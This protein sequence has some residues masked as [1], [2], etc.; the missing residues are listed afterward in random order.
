M[1]TEG[2]DTYWRLMMIKKLRKRFILIATVAVASVM[3]LLCVT[4][5][6]ANFVSV[7]SRLNRTVDMIVSNSGMM[8]QFD[9]R[10]PAP[11]ANVPGEGM[12]ADRF[13]MGGGQFNEETP[14]STR[15]FVLYYNADGTLLKSDLDK[16]AAVTQDDTS[17]YLELALKHGEGYG[18]ADGYKYKVEKQSDSSYMA[19]F[20]DD[21]REMNSLKTVLIFSVIATVV[22]IVLIYVLIVLF[23]GKAMRPVEQSVLKQ[24]QF[25][26]DA[27]HE[28]KTP[29][30]V[31]ATSMSVLE[32]EV[33][34]QKWIDKA[35]AQTEKLGE[36]VNSL[37]ALAKMDELEEP[38][39]VRE[40]DVSESLGETA[41]SFTDFAQSK[42]LSL[43]IKVQPQLRY[44]G[45]EYAVRQLA[46]ILIDNA[47]KYAVDGTV[48]DFSLEKGKKGIV[49][50]T[51]NE[52]E[53]IET[54]DL[55]RLFDRFYR[56]DKARSSEKGGFGI[57]LS[58]ARS[59]CEAHKGSIKASCDN[60]HTIV[61]TA[62]LK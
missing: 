45:D 5:N 51:S 3:L 42:G 56:A 46:S 40:F 30:T 26:T 15:F 4:V 52:C 58:I 11:D 31:I 9:R 7:N 47:I 21:Y 54:D 36:L 14:F 37:V 18:F 39:N 13:D 17:G 34:K 60:G 8:P 53:K 6:A 50:K 12:R 33:G 23:S 16:I 44:S 29:I 59:I 32:M 48:I 38:S 1:P 22:C 49:I 10:E 28:L 27:S 55:D 24:K 20:L 2:S 62:Q 19:V 41:D 25:I 57:G 35:K 61:F 43:N